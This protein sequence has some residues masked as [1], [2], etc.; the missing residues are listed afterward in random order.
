MHRRMAA[1]SS[2]G[3]VEDMASYVP[4]KG[5]MDLWIYGFMGLGSMG[6]GFRIYGLRFYGSMG[7][8]LRV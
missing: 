6:L 3:V 7:L 8:G 2:A 5:S 4:F 1:A